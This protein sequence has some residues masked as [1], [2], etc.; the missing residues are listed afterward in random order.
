MNDAPK[1]S[2]DVIELVSI[3]RAEADP[4]GIPCIDVND[5]PHKVCAAPVILWIGEGAVGELCGAGCDGVDW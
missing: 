5:V 2:L 3:L 4:M 1:L